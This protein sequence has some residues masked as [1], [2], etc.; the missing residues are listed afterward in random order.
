MPEFKLTTPN[1]PTPTDDVSQENN[2]KAQ[3][4]DI[5][6]IA[7]LLE[8]ID[9]LHIRDT[10]RFNAKEAAYKLQRELHSELVARVDE[11]ENLLYNQQYVDDIPF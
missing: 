6:L 5:G 4:M 2:S 8:Q 7:R 3:L 9:H 10:Y 1:R 11:L